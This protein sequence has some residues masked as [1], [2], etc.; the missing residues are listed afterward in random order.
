VREPGV[1]RAR[2]H[3][4]GEPELTHSTQT[5]DLAR[6][7]ERQR[8]SLFVAL[9]GDETVD[10]IS[11]NHGAWS[12]MP[13]GLRTLRLGRLLGSERGGTARRKP[14]GRLDPGVCGLDM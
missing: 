3:E 12:S 9:E 13:A 4:R 5:L 1:L 10:G 14:T 7:E 8:E 6:V 11:E 2:K